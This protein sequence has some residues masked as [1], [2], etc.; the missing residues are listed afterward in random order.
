MAR[1]DELIVAPCQHDLARRLELA[2]DLHDGALGRLDL[3]HPGRAEQL[4]LLQDVLGGPLGDVAEELVA[5][6]R[7]ARSS[8]PTARSFGTTL[9]RI[10]CSVRSSRLAT[11]SK[12]NI[13]LRIC[14]A[15]SGSV[16]SSSAQDLLLR[17]PLG[18]V[19]DGDDG[20]QPAHRRWPPATPARSTAASFCS[21]NSATWWT[22]S[23]EIRSM[24]AIRRATSVRVDSSRLAMTWAAESGGQVRQHQGD[25]A[26]DARRR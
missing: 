9:R 16:C 5:D 20:R 1:L 6:R 21:R 10:C 11:S 8:G 18:L 17:G 24:V 22:T 26:G 19:Q 13:S 15:S 3:R 4:D 2:D 12:T 25:R 23:G 14:S 7:R